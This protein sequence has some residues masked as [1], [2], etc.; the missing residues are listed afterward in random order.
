M[1]KLLTQE[2]DR[3]RRLQLLRSFVELPDPYDRQA[4]AIVSNAATGTAC[5]D[6]PLHPA[7]GRGDAMLAAVDRAVAEV[8]AIVGRR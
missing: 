6:S 3:L 2:Q 7:Q 1:S 5:G 8:A 4:Y